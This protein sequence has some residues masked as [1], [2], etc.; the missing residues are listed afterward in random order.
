[1]K[2]AFLALIVGFTSGFLVHAYFFP[3][4][5]SNG[6]IFTPENLLSNEVSPTP[7]DQ[8]Q[9]FTNITYNGEKFSRSNVTI[10]TGDYIT[11]TNDSPDKPMWLM[12]NV[13]ALSTPRGYGESEQVKSR[14]DTKGQFIIKD[15]N[16]PSEQVIITVK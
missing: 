15:K 5:L 4:V 1:M 11:V 12:S 16:N 2:K 10:G 7:N 9:L 8:R 13:P 3:D 14:M 6:I